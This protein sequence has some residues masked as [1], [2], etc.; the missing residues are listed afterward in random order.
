MCKHIAKYNC[1]FHCDFALLEQELHVLRRN[2]TTLMET[3]IRRA[4]IVTQDRDKNKAQ[5]RSEYRHKVQIKRGTDLV[6][7]WM[8]RNY[9]GTERSIISVQGNPHTRLVNRF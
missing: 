7:W 5:N 4:L 1:T 3:L 2:K 8:R 6:C 9:G